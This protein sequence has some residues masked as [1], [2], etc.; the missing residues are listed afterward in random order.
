MDIWITDKAWKKWSVNLFL[1][2]FL[3]LTF[4]Q[5]VYSFRGAF[6]VNN[7][8]SPFLLGILRSYTIKDNR[9]TLVNLAIRYDLGYN[10]IV[11]ANPGIDPWYP[12][13]GTRVVIPTI[14]ITPDIDKIGDD[15]I[16]INLAEMRLFYYKKLNTGKVAI[17]TFPIGIGSEGRDT[18]TGEYKIIQKLKNPVWVVPSSIRAEDPSLPEKVPPGPDN[19]LG[20]YAL[21]LSNP[22]YLIHGTNKPLGIGRR[23]S[24]GCLR[25]YPEDIKTL[26]DLVKIGTVVRIIYE[27]I[28]VLFNKDGIYVEAHKDYRNNSTGFNSAIKKLIKSG[29]VHRIDLKELYM[30]L[31]KHDGIPHLLKFRD[32]V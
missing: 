27:P 13:R 19:P 20:R 28:K 17:L 16:V 9:E 21:R 26:Y 8:K 30:I 25:M 5:R 32:R 1:S 12:G 24:H 7:S 29:L 2:V 23:V 11:D 4:S 3:I 6:V 14:W 31:D 10:E 15:L 18:P 22:S